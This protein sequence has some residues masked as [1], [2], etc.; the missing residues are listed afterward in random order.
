MASGLLHP[1]S[2]IAAMTSI[3]SARRDWDEG[4]R[5]FADEVRGDPDRADSLYR[6]RDAV[7]AE[8]RRRVGGVYTLTELTDVYESAER[9]V[10]DVAGEEAAG[11]AWPGTVTFASDAAFHAYSMGAQDYAP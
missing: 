8:L 3:A 11:L 2:T 10:L 5:R 4:R 7:L 9:W 6:Q 1:V